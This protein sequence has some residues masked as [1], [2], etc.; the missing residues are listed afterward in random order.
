MDYHCYADDIQLYVSFTPNQED[1]IRTLGKL[2]A[3]VHD[4]RQWMSSNSLKL[5]DD[6][7]QFLCFGSKAH[8]NKLNLPSLKIGDVTIPLSESCRNLGVIF[9]PSL[10][11]SSHISSVCRSARYYLRNL[12]VIRRYLTR[13]ATEKIVHAFISSRFDFGNALLF[14]LPQIQLTRLQR[15]QNAAARIIT[16][17]KKKDHITPVLYSLHW[18][19]IE[20]RIIFKLLLLVFHCVHGSAPE[21]NVNLI[22]PYNPPRRLRSSNTGLIVVPKVSTNWGDRSF[23]H[24]GPFLWNELPVHLRNTPNLETFKT[25]LKSYLFILA[26]D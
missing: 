18:L 12:G 8:L 7:S 14:Q 5:N 6:K 3:C 20:S 23:A 24:A 22:K 11:M 4:V 19:P 21:Y 16:L 15:L 13:S 9:D 17:T 25:N 2:E 26:F 1:A 10:S